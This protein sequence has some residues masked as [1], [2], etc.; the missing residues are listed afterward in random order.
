[1]SSPSFSAPAT[2]NASAKSF[3]ALPSA[4]MMS[5]EFDNICASQI[6]RLQSLTSE[7]PSFG[8]LLEFRA[9]SMSSNEALRTMYADSS[10][11][12]LKRTARVL[13]SLDN[14]NEQNLVTSDKL[15][16]ISSPLVLAVGASQTKLQAL[17]IM[18]TPAR[19]R[20]LLPA[21]KTG[22]LPVSSAT[23]LRALVEVTHSK[24]QE[25]IA[26]KKTHQKM[27]S[28]S[29]CRKNQQAKSGLAL[30]WKSVKNVVAQQMRQLSSL[31]DQLAL[32]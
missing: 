31:L 14:D 10:V 25:Q 27:L 1:M 18:P 20:N 8:Q 21:A 7:Q 24:R 28:A 30:V 6:Q 29:T 2:E 11:V 19:R 16:S 32:A 17:P 5:L 22:M 23:E 15:P 4:E 13:A 12:R 9:G 26:H 3:L